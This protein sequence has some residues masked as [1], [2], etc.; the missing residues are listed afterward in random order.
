MPKRINRLKTPG[1]DPVQYQIGVKFKKIPGLQVTRKLIDD[2]V[3]Q[4]CLTG[5]QTFA[6]GTI[7]IIVVRWKNPYRQNMDLAMWKEATTPRAIATAHE[8]LHLRELIQQRPN[9]FRSL[10]AD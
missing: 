2:V 5:E 1:A 10:R 3:R 8:T 9:V 6:R 4:F 7:R